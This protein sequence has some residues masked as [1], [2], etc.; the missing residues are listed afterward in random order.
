M[1]VSELGEKVKNKYPEYKDL[2]AGEVGARVL[3]KYP[4]YR[5]VVDTPVTDV[6]HPENYASDPLTWQPPTPEQEEIY[7]VGADPEAGYVQ[8]IAEAML[9]PSELAL[10][11]TTGALS[12]ARHGV[13]EAGKRALSWGTYGGS[14]VLKGGKAFLKEALRH[15]TKIE[16]AIPAE[17]A[18]PR[19][20]EATEAATM[21]TKGAVESASKVVPAGAET[22]KVGL[23]QIGPRAGSFEGFKKAFHDPFPDQSS[24]VRKFRAYKDTLSAGGKQIRKGK[25]ALSKYADSLGLT[26]KEK[27]YLRSTGELPHPEKLVPSKP[28]KEAL[29]K[30][31]VE[32]MKEITPAGKGGFL[33]GLQRG[34]ETPIRM[35]EKLDP[36]GKVKKAVYDP[37]DDADMAAVREFQDHY[38]PM[39]KRWKDTKV[40]ADRIGTYMV[41]RQKEGK[42]ILAL[43][44]KKIPDLTEAEYRVVIEMDAEYARLFDRINEARVLSGMKPI[45]KV[46]N[47]FTFFKKLNWYKENLGDDILSRPDPM[48]FLNAEFI[49]GTTEFIHPS[50]T[51]L[52][53]AKGRTK[54]YIAVDTNAFRSFE[55]YT[56]KT[57]EHIHISPKIAKARDLMNTIK[58]THTQEYNDVTN[59]L[60]YAAGIRSSGIEKWTNKSVENGIRKLTNNVSMA[61]LA[62]NVRS[63]AIQPSVMRNTL[64][65][66][67]PKYTIEGAM[68]IFSPERRKF[69]M[70]NSNIIGRKFDA[71]VAD[72]M[73]G[74]GKAKTKVTQ[75]AMKPLAWLDIQAAMAS[76]DAFYRKATG[77]YKM[78]HKAAVRWANDWVIK[79][80]ASGRNIHRSKIQRSTE[81]QTLTAL[82]TF[83]INDWSF[84]TQDVLGLGKNVPMSKENVGRVLY[85]IGGTILVNSIYE[86]GLGVNSP[87]GTPVRKFKESRDA[88]LSMSESTVESIKELG[89][90]VPGLGQARFG[91]GDFG[92]PLYSTLKKA[93]GSLVSAAGGDY[94]SL[95]EPFAKLGGLPGTAQT[96]KYLQGRE[97][98]ESVPR[99]IIGSKS[100]LEREKKSRTKTSWGSS[101]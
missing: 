47:Y 38:V 97:G 18:F 58:D 87:Y 19:V 20:K 28:G 5:E 39:V 77:A 54:N 48:K 46:E 49:E 100:R 26:K 65:I 15:P 95:I 61:I 79:T 57:L 29:W 91:E 80:N 56:G 41:S 51:S 82:Q 22:A 31:E 33:K 8:N 92:G 50:G 53:F 23:E 84:L 98:G 7:K 2:S 11:A 13:K 44:R 42:K 93:G 14:D 63:A 34:V 62:G 78:D 90:V 96:S 36:T 99:S 74:M 72:F 75:A 64:V 86:D 4:E 68:S 89:D 52:P 24:N 83:V 88:G 40:D 30:T 6:S 9:D 69:I 67:R 60:D 35:F 101:W 10:M 43:M 66:A 45:G 55:K 81:G 85:Y 94:A 59:W 71:T 27:Q 16:K 17:K 76:W 3:K 32:A 37:I 12:G 21:A 70:D 1:N 73:S 25:S